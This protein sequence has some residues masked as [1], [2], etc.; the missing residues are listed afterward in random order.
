MKELQVKILSSLIGNAVPLPEYSTDGSAGL[1]LRAC[2]ENQLC[3]NPGQ[4]RKSVV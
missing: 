2:L 1:D 4:D 3:L